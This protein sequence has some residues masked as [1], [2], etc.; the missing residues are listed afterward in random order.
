MFQCVSPLNLQFE[1][2]YRCN[3]HCVFCYNNSYD[4][5][6]CSERSEIS[7]EDAKNVIQNAKDSGVMS[8]N[9]NGG[10]P[11]CR[12]D[13]FEIATFAKDC[14]LDIHLNTNASLINE[15]KAQQIS[16]LFPSICTTILSGDERIHDSLSKRSGAFFDAIKGIKLLQ[17]HT[18]YVAVNLMLCSKNC[19]NIESAFDL[20]RSLNIKTLLITRYVPNQPNETE[21]PISDDDFFL[22]IRKLRDYQEEYKCFDRI[23]LPQPM[24][25]CIVPHEIFQA[26]YDWNIPCNIGLCTASIDAYGDITPCNLIKKPV[27]GNAVTTSLAE[28]WSLFDGVTYC[29]TQHLMQQCLQCTY[30][31]AC[32]GGC[33]GFNL[34]TENK[35]NTNDL[36]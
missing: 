36:L 27:L 28:I 10:E 13:F 6:E 26:V 30:I 14:G 34:T 17:K 29:K 7:T 24:K 31:E 32:G 12:T 25:L 8:L 4:F 22:V 16:K 3:N 18:V 23:A 21:L 9:F 20:L 5:S 35:E 2:T 33:K 11:L 15:E 19:S 1:L